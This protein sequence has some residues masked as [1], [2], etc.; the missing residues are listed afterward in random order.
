MVWGSF[1]AAGLGSLHRISGT[2]DQYVYL[3]IL[4]NVGIPCAR[5]LLGDKLIYQQDNDPKHR[6]KR[7]RKYFSY[8]PN[9]IMDLPSQSPD[10]NPIEH[11]WGDLDRG[12]R[13]TTKSPT[14]ADALFERI[15]MLWE[16]TS[17]ETVQKLVA[18]MPSGVQE[19]IKNQGGPISY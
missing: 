18:S 14:S 7:V 15:R 5:R 10:L 17:Q 2:K 3:E 12:L 8:S 19:A 13:S 9:N 16:C 11:F 6:A 1:S 4:Q